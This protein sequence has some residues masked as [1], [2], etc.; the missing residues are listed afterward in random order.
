M[1]MFNPDMFR[2]N[3]MKHRKAYNRI[4]TDISLHSI[5]TCQG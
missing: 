3:V 4:T 1:T 5:E 2:S